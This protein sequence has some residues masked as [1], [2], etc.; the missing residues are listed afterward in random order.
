MYIFAN[1]KIISKPFMKRVTILFL[2]LT[3]LTINVMAQTKKTVKKATTPSKQTS[4]IAPVFKSNPWVF[5]FGKD[6]VYKSEFERLL[7]KNKN[8]KEIPDEKAVREYLELYENFKMK[9]S[10]AKIKHLDTASAFIN[11]L[12]GY[13]SQLAKPYLTDKKVTDDLIKEAYERMK[14]EINASHIL[15]NCAENASPKDSLAAYNKIL[16]LRKRIMKGERFDSVA[17]KNSEDPSAV[18]NLGL[19]GWFTSFHM[20]YP[21]ETHAYTTPKGEVSM[22][23]R[24]RFGYHLLKVNDKRA[25]RGEIQVAH[26]MV[27]LNPNITDQLLNDAKL[28]IDSAYDQLQK[29][30]AFETVVERFSQDDGSK[31]N[32]GVINWFGSFSNFPDDFKEMCFSLNKGETSKPFKTQYGYHIIKL[33]DKRPIADQK[34]LEESIK[35]KI[36]RDSRAESSKLVVAQRIKKENNYKEFSVNVKEF[37]SKLDSTF[38]KGSWNYDESKISDKPI[39]SLGNKTY[40][41]KDFAKFVQS[42]Q[43]A[44]LKGSIPFI[45]NGL[46]KKFSDEKALE[47]EENMLETKYEDFKNLMQEYHDG[48]LLFDLTDKM[49]WTKAVV[50]TT[51]L[52]KF[53]DANKMKYMWK[54]R[55]KVYTYSC[56]NEKAKSEAMKMAS[57][58]KSIDEIKAKLNKKIGGTVVVTDQKTEKNENPALDK[59]WDKK[60]VVDIANENS[61]FKFYFVQGVVAPEPKSLKEARGIATSDYQNYLEKEWI[62][63]LHDKY[64]VVVNEE[65]VKTLFK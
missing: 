9:V 10:E 60:G 40:S 61:T 42:N 37:S 30:V 21:F 64:P 49:V 3:A 51:G 1:P 8:A 39:I 54:E 28:K 15:I 43:E 45:L 33:I 5:T 24:T 32:K 13:R 11:E 58:G 63:S 55:L 31:A 22:P 6:T 52:E 12:S 20:I 44:Q 14:W 48:I 62:K 25:A 35:S 57:A 47:Y 50:D 41:E 34:D 29:G 36:S 19:L 23:F 26:I 7:S 2:V 56:L 65:T 53:H 18:K 46:I 59:M 38:L 4:E 17:V 27:R 16:E